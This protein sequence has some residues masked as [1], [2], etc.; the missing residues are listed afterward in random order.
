M[1]NDTLF[2]LPCASSLS[3]EARSLRSRPAMLT[4]LNRFWYSS[5]FTISTD[6]SGPRK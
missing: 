5:E 6:N 2:I 1:R 3:T 4:C